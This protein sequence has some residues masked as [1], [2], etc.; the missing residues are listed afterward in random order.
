MACFVSTTLSWFFVPQVAC[1]NQIPR[2]CSSAL[3]RVGI[4]IS[5][6]RPLNRPLDQDST[7]PN[8]SRVSSAVTF[9][10]YPGSPS[11]RVSTS[12]RL[13]RFMSHFR[14]RCLRAWSVVHKKFTRYLDNAR[15]S[16]TE[17]SSSLSILVHRFP[18]L[19]FLQ[20]NSYNSTST[21]HFLLHTLQRISQ[22]PLQKIKYYQVSTGPRPQLYP[23]L[24]SP[25]LKN[26]RVHLLQL[27]L[28]LRHPT[29]DVYLR[30]V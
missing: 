1:S 23:P 6:A 10:I 20:F 12:F 4:A 29:Q 11:R 28:R 5:L 27:D 30:E 17:V 26:V 14:T 7:A 18:V 9:G 15:D 21:E 24:L 8:I 2:T 22:L 19:Q 3:R 25:K 13:F 16:V